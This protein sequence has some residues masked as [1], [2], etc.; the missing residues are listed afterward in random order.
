MA[1]NK[2]A[3]RR[4]LTSL[5]KLLYNKQVG[6]PIDNLQST[7][8][9]IVNKTVADERLNFGDV[10]QKSLKNITPEDMASLNVTNSVLHQQD[11][12]PRIG[13]YLNSDEITDSI[14]YCARALKVIAD[15]TTSPSEYTKTSIQIQVEDDEEEDGDETL[16][17]KLETIEENIQFDDAVYSLVNDTLKYGDQFVEI[18]NTTSKSAPVQELL[19]SESGESITQDLEISGRIEYVVEGDI[20]TDSKGKIVPDTVNL[21]II[22]E[23]LK[24][25]EEINLEEVSD[26]RNKKTKKNL[27]NKHKKDEKITENFKNVKLVVHDPKTIIKLQS[28]RF[29]LNL[30]YLVFPKYD[31]N[32]PGL[33]NAMGGMHF[34]T[35]FMG[36]TG[37]ANIKSGVDTVYEK[38]LHA[39][40]GHINKIDDIDKES[41]KDLEQIVKNLIQST[42][43]EGNTQNRTLN[44]R[45]VPPEKMEHFF[46]SNKRF[47]PYGESI[48]QKVL[49]NAKLLIALETA[50]TIKR[51]SD[52]TEK[53]LIRVETSLPR[54]IKNTIEELKEASKKRRY[55]IDKLGN[56]GSIPS[57]ITSYEDIYVPML[58]GKSYIEFDKIEPGVNIRDV[59][60]ELKFFRD[61]VV[62]GLDVP[63]AFLNLEE[64]LSNKA[65]LNMENV[66]FARTILSYQKMFSKLMTSLFKKLYIAIYHQQP[67][68]SFKLT[69]PPPKTILIEYESEKFNLI[70]QIVSA[71]E[72][73]GLPKTYIREKYLPEIDWEEIDKLDREEKLK[74]KI[75][76]ATGGGEEDDSQGL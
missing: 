73:I 39:V 12:A 48:F 63:P 51:I 56:I 50:V 3:G 8:K 32:N 68:G 64:N 37:G 65:A 7:I 29:G 43:D 27:I 62:S 74:E 31:T 22:L 46:I 55:S 25:D 14:P 42:K 40:A 4:P 58:N 53:R 52:S 6:T 23:Y 66:L 49:F 17:S 18:I 20:T 1:E 28:K 70:G 11:I 13:R 67:K 47:F 15:E 69:F 24:D 45:Y 72:G 9:S 41:K 2:N 16:K 19:L 57:T 61:L 71:G 30:G 21:K 35:A 10:F 5:E 34:A 76:S 44:A 60:E 59:H 75:K 26:I 33:T 54:Q 36:N 38:L